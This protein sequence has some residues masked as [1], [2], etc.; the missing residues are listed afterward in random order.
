LKDYILNKK[1]LENGDCF[2]EEVDQE[3]SELSVQVDEFEYQHNFRFEH[4]IS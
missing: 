3:E 4:G 2:D 1:W